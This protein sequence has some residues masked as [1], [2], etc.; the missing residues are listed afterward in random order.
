MNDI[1]A[2]CSAFVIKLFNEKLSD[3]FTYHNLD[4]TLEVV[5]MASLIAD[6]SLTDHNQK[7][8]ILIACWFHDTGITE[9]YGNHEEASSRICR[10][11]LTSVN[12]PDNIDEICSAILATRIP[13]QPSGL[14][15]MVVC[16]ADISHT[17]KKDFYFKS[18]LLRREWENISGVKYNEYQWIKKNIDF[19]SSVRFYTDYAKKNFEEERL[20]NL[21]ELKN[22]MHTIIKKD[23][24]R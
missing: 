1:I 23:K 20:K 10:T 12:Y 11:F 6:H 9:E 18:S 3:E 4:H 5:E 8:K 13:S 14:T 17:G 22:L 21:E 2:E 24:Q 16:D 7:E 15:G 19:I